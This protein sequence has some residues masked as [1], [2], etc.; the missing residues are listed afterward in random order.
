[1]IYFV[2]ISEIQSIFLYCNVFAKLIE[3]VDFKVIKLN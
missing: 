1:M 2:L 3:L